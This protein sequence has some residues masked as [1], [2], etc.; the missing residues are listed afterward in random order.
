MLEDEIDAGLGLRSCLE[1]FEV[2]LEGGRVEGRG[3]DPEHPTDG[4]RQHVALELSSLQGM[5]A[6]P[7]D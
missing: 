5:E 1:A 2:L 4:N 3:G 7:V 6:S